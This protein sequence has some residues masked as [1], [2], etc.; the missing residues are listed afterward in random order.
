MQRD[1]HRLEREMS[2]VTE[3]TKVNES[4]ASEADAHHREL[5]VERARGR[6]LSLAVV[7]AALAAL[8]AGLV[9]LDLNGGLGGT[10]T[11]MRMNGTNGHASGTGAA[12]MPGQ[13][14]GAMSGRATGPAASGTSSIPVV[15][16]TL[17][18][19]Y[20]HPNMTT[21][22]AGKIEFT[23]R[24]VG[25]VEHEL[26]VERMPIKMDA[27][28]QPNEDAAQGM[29]QD[30]APGE[31]GKMTLN[32]KAGMYMLFCNVEGHFAAGQYT[33]LRVTGS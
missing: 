22:P 3:E 16:S 24:N 8:A 29:I 23:A 10:T 30:M 19:Y 17:G 25:K 20:I 21:V 6:V 33:M 31:S 2:T 9:A 7:F 4:P 32:L 18:E 1:N 26:M 5:E 27:P 12:N 15:S 28:G 11:V 14:G 13:M